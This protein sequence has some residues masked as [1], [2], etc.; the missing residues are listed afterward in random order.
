MMMKMKDEP[1]GIGHRIGCKVSWRVYASHEEAVAAAEI[2]KFNGRIRE[3][4]GYDS[5]YCSAGSIHEVANGYEV[6][7]L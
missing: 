2:A 3:A 6:C 4:M 1:K 5:G 7:F